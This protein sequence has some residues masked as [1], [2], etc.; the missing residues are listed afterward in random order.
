MNKED[1]KI[2]LLLNRYP[3]GFLYQDTREIKRQWMS[4]KNEYEISRT[5]VAN[6]FICDEAIF[7]FKMLSLCLLKPWTKK[8]RMF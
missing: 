5:D 1:V 2:I 7:L 3:A 4:Q 8:R 6:L